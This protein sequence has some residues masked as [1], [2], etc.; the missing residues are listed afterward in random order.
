MK[1]IITITDDSGAAPKASTSEV[2]ATRS[3]LEV[4][5]AGVAPADPSAPA[6]ANGG[7]GGG[8]EDG[9]PA[10]EWL[11]ELIEATGPG[12]TGASASASAADPAAVDGGSAPAD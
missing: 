2:P 10:P 11:R 4:G 12:S 3:E 1:T 6:A 7:H 8:G 9:G 5:D